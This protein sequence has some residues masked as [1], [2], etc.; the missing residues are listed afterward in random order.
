MTLH[1]LEMTT[2]K[3]KVLGHMTVQRLTPK[4][5]QK[6]MKICSP[7]YIHIQVGLC[8]YKKQGK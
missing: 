1:I 7:T 5:N 2:Q 8:I 3:S 4:T 6:I